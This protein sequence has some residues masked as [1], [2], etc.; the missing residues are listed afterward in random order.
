M[1]LLMTLYRAAVRIL[2]FSPCNLSDNSKFV[3]GSVIFSRFEFFSNFWC[4][5]LICVFVSFLHPRCCQ[6]QH[7]PPLSTP[8]WPQ[9]N[10]PRIRDGAHDWLPPSYV[11]SVIVPMRWSLLINFV[12]TS[13]PGMNKYGDSRLEPFHCWAIDMNI[14][15][16]VMCTPHN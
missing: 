12:R 2:F 13:T 11:S 14:V 4:L 5:R 9:G 8:W 6:S 16:Q 15:R 7:R 3:C 10:H 1:L